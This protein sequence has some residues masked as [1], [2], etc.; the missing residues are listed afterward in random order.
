MMAK[1]PFDRHN[2]FARSGCDKRCSGALRD[3]LGECGCVLL[4]SACAH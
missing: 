1:G 2:N 4:H 3:C